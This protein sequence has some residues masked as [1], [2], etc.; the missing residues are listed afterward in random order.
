MRSWKLKNS[1]KPHAHHQKPTHF[2]KPSSAQRS[3]K[4]ITKPKRRPLILSVIHSPS[5]LLLKPKRSSNR[6]CAHHSSGKLG[7]LSNTPVA[8]RNRAPRPAGNS[9]ATTNFAYN[10]PS[11]PLNKPTT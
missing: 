5:V 9:P 3:G 8:K 7:R 1:T 2:T 10:Q 11:T 4:P 6:N